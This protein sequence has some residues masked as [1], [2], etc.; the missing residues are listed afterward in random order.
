MGTSAN[1][2]ETNMSS[3]GLYLS[4]SP[5]LLFAGISTG[6]LSLWMHK[7]LSSTWSYSPPSLRDKRADGKLHS[8]N[9]HHFVNAWRQRL[10]HWTNMNINYHTRD[11]KWCAGKHCSSL[12]WESERQREGELWSE[13]IMWLMTCKWKIKWQTH[14]AVERS[15][16]EKL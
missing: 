10:R 14:E 12:V 1:R 16:G 2:K 6:S 13:P 9:H 5:E 15:A 7:G 8:P 3:F 4:L 11:Q